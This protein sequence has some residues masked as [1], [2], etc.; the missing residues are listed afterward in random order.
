MP[1]RKRKFIEEEI[2]LRN[3]GYIDGGYDSALREGLL[4][5]NL[6]GQDFLYSVF[7]LGDLQNVTSTG[8]TRDG[9]RDNI[10][11]AYT[12]EQLKWEDNGNPNALGRLAYDCVEPAIAVYCKRQFL[13]A[14]FA[15]SD[16][17]YKFINE[18]SKTEALKGIVC[19]I[20]D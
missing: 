11:Y 13:P 15:N 16:Y 19:L 2:D 17:G 4:G 8:M 18:D 9:S 3:L 12:Y 14:E 1:I 5:M 20:L 10:I 6:F 7:S